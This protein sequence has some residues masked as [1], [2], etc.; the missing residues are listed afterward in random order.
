MAEQII[1]FE[2]G[3]AYEQMMGI[4]SRLVGNV[5]LQWLAPP[6]GLR[7]IDVGC[8]N[9]A[10]TEVLI[11]RCAPTWVEGIDPSEGQLAYA[12][13]RLSIDQANFSKGDAMALPFA[14]HS[15]DAAVMALVLVFVSDPRKAVEEMVRVV[16]PGGRVATY[17]W[18]MLGDGFP[19]EPILLEMHNMGL[20]PPRPPRMEASSTEALR[21]LW[22]R[23]GLDKVEMREIRVHRV[24]ANFDDFW[25]AKQTA[26]S[27][28]ATIAAMSS[29]EVKTLKE[30]VRAR[31]PSDAEGRITYGARANAILGRVPA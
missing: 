15:F 1:R 27:I 2:D 14:N 3:A 22:E 24:F 4:W 25:L 7:W 10:F 11:E 8:G 9:G 12:R 13:K 31:L 19:L 29:A 26:P 21:D 23:A 18:D 17:M 30:R 6:L 20:A 16:K 28:G 5:F